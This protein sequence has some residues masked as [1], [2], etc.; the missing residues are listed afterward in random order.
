[1]HERI[2]MRHYLYSSPRN[3][4]PLRMDTDHLVR[5]T[6]TPHTAGTLLPL[7]RQLSENNKFISSPVQ[8]LG[9]MIIRLSSLLSYCLSHLTQPCDAMHTDA[10]HPTLA[11]SVVRPSAHPSVDNK[12]NKTIRHKPL[13]S[14][15]GRVGAVWVAWGAYISTPTPASNRD[16]TSSSPAPNDRDRPLVHPARNANPTPKRE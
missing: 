7:Q 12:Q 1:M 4:H 8:K 9:I 3:H 5:N 11:P 14:L 13:L 16:P 6:H 15:A 2:P 10:C